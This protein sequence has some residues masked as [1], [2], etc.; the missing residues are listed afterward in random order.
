[1]LAAAIVISYLPGDR[2]TLLHH[3][4]LSIPFALFVYVTIEYVT[5]FSVAQLQSSSGAFFTPECC[6]SL[7]FVRYSNTSKNHIPVSN[8]RPLHCAARRSVS[9]LEHRIL[10]HCG[11]AVLGPRAK[12]WRC[13][14]VCC[15]S[16]VED[17]WSAAKS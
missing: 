5:I 4:F 8:T 2:E 12:T 13:T 9:R 16:E 14:S 10:L 11:V 6:R 7:L 3:C 15:M 1:V 17:V